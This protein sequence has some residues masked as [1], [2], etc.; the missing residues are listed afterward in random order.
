MFLKNDLLHVQRL[1]M[2]NPIFHPKKLSI[3]FTFQYQQSGTESTQSVAIVPIA[4]NQQ[5]CVHQVEQGHH[6][7]VAYC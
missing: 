5:W 3:F 2:T 1:N 6:Q 7:Y 4:S